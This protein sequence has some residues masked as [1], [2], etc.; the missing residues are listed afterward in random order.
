MA[1]TS[2]LAPYRSISNLNSTCCQVWIFKCTWLTSDRKFCCR[3]TTSVIH[4]HGK[5]TDVQNAV[6]VFVT[7]C[8]WSFVKFICL[9]KM[10]KFCWENIYRKLCCLVDWAKC[11]RLK[12]VNF[13]K[14]TL[15]ETHNI[16][17]MLLCAK[18]D[19]LVLSGFYCLIKLFGAFCYFP[20]LWNKVVTWVWL[21]W[22][23]CWDKSCATVE[24]CCN[25]CYQLIFGLKTQFVW[26][27][28][29]AGDTEVEL[30]ILMV[31]S[32]TPKKVILNMA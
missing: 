24:F 10:S 19:M 23:G 7:K 2:A 8:S 30:H 3:N 20:K 27:L 17:N 4:L 31:V 25:T 15:L 18:S 9:M 28:F 29:H 21:F 22:Y 11:G 12:S 32:K 26:E 5:E 1:D 16:I 14:F 6:G 13:L